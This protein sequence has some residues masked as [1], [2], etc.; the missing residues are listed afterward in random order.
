MDFGNSNIKE[1]MGFG[2]IINTLVLTI[3]KLVGSS[4]IINI[5]VGINLPS[6]LVGIIVA[7]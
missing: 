1:D 3:S 7:L 5:E 2:I 4:S 6:Y